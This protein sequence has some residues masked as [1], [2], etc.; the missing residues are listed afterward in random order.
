MNGYVFLSLFPPVC[1]CRTRVDEQIA[2]WRAD[3]S[4]FS[5]FFFSFTAFSRYKS[6]MKAKKGRLLPLERERGRESKKDKERKREKE[7]VS[8]ERSKEN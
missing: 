5:A 7:R 4:R 1:A 2:T 6:S 3:L 8:N